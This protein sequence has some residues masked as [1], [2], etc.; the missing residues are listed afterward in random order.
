MKICKRCGGTLP[1][2][3][4]HKNGNIKDGHDNTCRHCRTKH[5]KQHNLV[6]EY[7]GKHFVSKYKNRYCGA[8]CSGKARRKREMRVCSYCGEPVEVVAYKAR[9]QDVF[10]CNQSCR[11]EHLKEIMS[12]ENNPNYSRVD[13]ECDGCGKALKVIPHK[14]ESQDYI[15]CSGE[16]YR[17]NIGKFFTGENNHNYS[18]V[19]MSCRMCGSTFLRQPAQANTENNFCSRECY[20]EYRAT[21]DLKESRVQMLV[22]G[23]HYCGVTFKRYPS[24]MHNKDRFFCSR[25]CKNAQFGVDQSG[26]NHPRWN[27]D[28]TSEEREINRKFPEYLRWRVAVYERDEYTC[29]A[30]GDDSGGNLNAHHIINYSED[31][32]ARLDV[33]NGVT[34]CDGCHRAFHVEHGYTSNTEEQIL[35]Y[36]HQ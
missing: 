12:G 10:Y 20:M 27:P 14:Q 4:F 19:E 33:E 2:S 36:L 29:R 17:E 7:C 21:A 26:E 22:Y 6:C 15:F 28:L 8:K 25:E 32:E 34:L 31:R 16:C 30:C 9:H 35:E 24:Q 3:E 23:C 13:Y 11:T 18:Q 5:R 1:L